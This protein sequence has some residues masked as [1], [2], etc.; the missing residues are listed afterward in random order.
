VFGVPGALFAST[1]AKAY[2]FGVTSRDPLTI[3]AAV[4]VLLGAALMAAYAPARAAARLDPMLA[5]RRE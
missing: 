5:L 1:F 3:V 2:L 4:A